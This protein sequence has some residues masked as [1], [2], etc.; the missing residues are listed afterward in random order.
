MTEETEEQD[1]KVADAVEEDIA[2][3]QLEAAQRM[4]L[5]E[6][7]KQLTQSE[8]FQR[9]FSINYEVQTY[10]DKKDQTFDIRLIELPPELASKRLQE[11]AAKHAEENL[12]SVQPATM[13]DIAALNDIENRQK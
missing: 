11:L 2:E 5:S 12:P 3:E 10:F 4:Y 13:A 6:V 7:M 1:V 8:R 9:F